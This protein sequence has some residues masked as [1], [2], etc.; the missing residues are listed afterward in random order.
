[1]NRQDKRKIAVVG[2]GYVGLPLAVHFAEK[3]E[4]I[5]FDLDSEKINKYISGKDPTEE[6]GENAIKASKITFTDNPKKLREANFIIVAVPTPINLDKSPN[7]QPLLKASKLVGENMQGNGTI[8]V[9]ESTV[10]PGVTEEKCVPE[11][12]KASGMKCGEDF[13]V[14]YSPERIN[15]GD[16]VYTLKTIKKIV[17]AMD[18]KTLEVIAKTYSQIIEAGVH[19]AENIKVAEAAKVLENSQRDVNIAFMNEMAM[20][21]H[22]MGINTADVIRAM[23]TKWNALNFVPGLVGGHCIGVDPYYFIYEAENQGYH[24]S[25]ISVARRINDDMPKEVAYE[26]VKQII[27]A[28][29]NPREA[30]VYMLGLTFKGNCPDLRNTKS[31]IVM[32]TLE[33]YKMNV[34]ITDSRADQEEVAAVFGKRA[35]PFEEI[36]EADCLIFAANHREYAELEAYQIERF[37]D[38]EGCRLIMDICNIYSQKKF[39]GSNIKYWN[40]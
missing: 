35:I 17:S 25:I 9:Y 14:G 6:V 28:G 18:E 16:K 2:L 12:E 3:F 37:L 26:I 32:K 4:V 10:Y 40:L 15:P 21:C 33:A 7:L 31:E 5:G 27:L 23:N 34:E 20:A 29:K 11:L 22:Q 24:S 39:E 13:Y 30:K 19:K 8:V 38:K 36:S 1:M